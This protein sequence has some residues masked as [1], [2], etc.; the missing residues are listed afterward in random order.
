MSMLR[1]NGIAAET[2]VGSDPM[3]MLLGPYPRVAQIQAAIING[4][5]LA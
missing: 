4:V 5:V 3:A 1:S 2:M